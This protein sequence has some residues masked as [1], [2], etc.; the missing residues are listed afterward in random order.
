[1][2]QVILAGMLS[3]PAAEARGDGEFAHGPQWRAPA[4]EGE[5]RDVLTKLFLMM[6]AA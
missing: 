3:Q 2:D 1:M 5:Y 4:A 6:Q